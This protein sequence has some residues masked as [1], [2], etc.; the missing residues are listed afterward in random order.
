VF[1]IPELWPY[2]SYSM[3]LL[4]ILLIFEMNVGKFVYQSAREAHVGAIAVASPMHSPAAGAAA[5]TM[6]PSSAMPSM[7]SFSDMSSKQV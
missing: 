4:A 5:A 1:C 7:A 6:A 3:G 2:Q